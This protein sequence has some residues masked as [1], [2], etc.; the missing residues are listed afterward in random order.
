MYLLRFGRGGRQVLGYIH[1]GGP[2]LTQ[3]E[4]PDEVGLITGTRREPAVST[5]RASIR[6]DC[7]KLGKIYRTNTDSKIICRIHVK[8]LVCV[9]M[10]NV[11]NYRLIFGFIWLFLHFLT[12]VLHS[13]HNSSVPH[14]N[15][16][17][18]ELTS[19]ERSFFLSMTSSSGKRE[20]KLK[21]TSWCQLSVASTPTAWSICLDD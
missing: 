8:Y 9:L 15:Y 10:G 2:A 7:R 17:N 12:Y 3:M 1:S 20:I 5:I 21:D 18:W 11:F 19:K 14:F 16:R 6:L 4:R 13:S